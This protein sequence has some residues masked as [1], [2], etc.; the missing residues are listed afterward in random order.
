MKTRKTYLRSAL[1]LLF[2]ATATCAFADTITLNSLDQ[3]WY[4]NT[5][6]NDPTNS[7]YVVGNAS[8]GGPWNDFFTFDASALGGQTV[9][10]ATLRIFNPID[11]FSS[12]RSSETVSIGS[13]AGSLTDLVSGNGGIAAYNALGSGNVFGSA[14]IS[15]ADNNGWV[16]FVLNNDFLSY[17]NSAPGVF[18]LGGTLSTLDATYTADQYAFA[19]SGNPLTIPQLVLS[20]GV[21]SVPETGTGSLIEIVMVALVLA[22]EFYRKMSLRSHC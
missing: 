18:A 20:T 2:T 10:G 11:G 12:Y 4:D 13:F 14:S 16:Q 15:S 17:F 22:Y 7:D 21:A 6:F 5:G 19:F 1:A 8:F 3:G 9:T